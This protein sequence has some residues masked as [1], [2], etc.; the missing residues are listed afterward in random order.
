MIVEVLLLAGLGWLGL[1]IADGWN[2]VLLAGAVVLFIAAVL[3][4]ISNLRRMP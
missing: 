4:G 2:L 3:V 1:G